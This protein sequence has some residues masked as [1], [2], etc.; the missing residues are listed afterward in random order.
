MHPLQSGKDIA[1]N[2]KNHLQLFIKESFRNLFF[3]MDLGIY[4]HSY[5]ASA[6]VS[7]GFV[8]RLILPYGGK[9]DVV[10]FQRG[11]IPK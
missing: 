11:G 7:E 1:E 9:C 3:E 8:P 4:W 5:F 2:L 10:V 6:L